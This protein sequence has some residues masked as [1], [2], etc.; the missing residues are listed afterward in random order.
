MSTDE[1]PYM[2]WSRRELILEIERLGLR[3]D[4]ALRHIKTIQERDEVTNAPFR[5]V[6]IPARIARFEDELNAAM[7]TEAHITVTASWEPNEP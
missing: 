7:G 4:D 6:D 3:G 2:D 1:R 5:D